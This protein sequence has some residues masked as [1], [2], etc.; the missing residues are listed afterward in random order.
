MPHRCVAKDFVLS[1]QRCCCSCAEPR[2]NRCAA[3]LF[4]QETAAL[5]R[6]LLAVALL[7]RCRAAVSEGW[8][9]LTNR[10][11]N[12]EQW[13]ADNVELILDG[14][15]AEHCENGENC[16]A[17]GFLST[18]MVSYAGTVMNGNP[19]GLELDYDPL[20]T[21]FRK[22]ETFKHLLDLHA[23]DHDRCV[24]TNMLEDQ[25]TCLTILGAAHAAAKTKTLD[26]EDVLHNVAKHQSVL[27]EALREHREE[28]KRLRIRE[29]PE[30]LCC[31]ITCI[32]MM[33][34]VLCVEDGHTYERVA[35]EQWFAT[36]ARTSPATSA[37]LE[38]TALV[39]NHVVRKLITALKEQ[40]GGGAGRREE[41]L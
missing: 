38:S 39:P 23:S 34:P 2:A 33:D 36:G 41:L 40:H 5:M 26:T 4:A 29:L 18:L 6:T 25:M 22:P 37:Q 15:D 1:S 14:L 3:A 21:Q 20:F 16:I 17:R 24:R 8:E 35:I 11:Q 28:I 31:P 32:I 27:E 30:D 12:G 19:N 7:A 10:I 9:R 13:D